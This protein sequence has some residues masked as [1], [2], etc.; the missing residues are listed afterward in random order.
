MEEIVYC[1]NGGCPFTDCKKNLKNLTEGI[2]EG[3]V[4]IADLD[5][6]CRRYIGW[7]VDKARETR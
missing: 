3:K 5:S 4:R 2:T 1:V 7:L 6:V